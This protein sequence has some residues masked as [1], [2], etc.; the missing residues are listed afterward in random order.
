MGVKSILND[1]SANWGAGFDKDVVDGLTSAV[2]KIGQNLENFTNSKTFSE[3]FLLKIILHFE[4]F[5]S[6]SIIKKM[7]NRSEEKL[8]MQKLSQKS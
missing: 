4:S 7:G 2:V 8:L 6:K 5:Q 3:H 1:G